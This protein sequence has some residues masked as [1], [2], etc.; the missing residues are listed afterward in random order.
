MSG[1][2]V[3]HTNVTRVKK[4][5]D[6]LK[7]QD[8]L[9]IEE[10]LEIKLGYGDS[11]QRKELLLSITMRTPGSD[12]AL[13]A[14]FLLGEGIISDFSQIISIQH[15]ASSP[16]PSNTIRVELVPE[17]NINE[18]SLKRNFISNASCGVCGKTTLDQIQVTSHHSSKIPLHF[19]LDVL[20][21]MPDKLRNN[22][23]VFGRTGGLHAAGI[24]S[25]KGEL[26][27]I[28][29]DIGRHNAVDKVIGTALLNKIELSD[30]VILLSGRVGYELMQ[31]SIAARIPIVVAIGAP[32]SL[33]AEMAGASGTMLIGFLKKDTFNIYSGHLDKEEN[34][35]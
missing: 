16:T 3:A 2:S 20:Y 12:E 32:S 15:C 7:D 21:S 9:A 13:A 6:S 35:I 19:D 17:V 23:L 8:L 1:I 24:F 27:L 34:K 18:A 28:S 25:I 14:G 33:A 11:I 26:L 22:Q 5:T 4:D 30:K 29:E 31:K 10:P